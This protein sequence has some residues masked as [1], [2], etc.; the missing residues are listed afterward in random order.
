[1]QSSSIAW[2]ASKDVAVKLDVHVRTLRNW[3]D[4]F[5][6]YMV[7]Q[8][9]SQ[10]HLLLS[11]QAYQL[12]VEIK[13]RKDTGVQTLKEVEDSLR[14]DG[15]LP[16]RMETEDLNPAT[17]HQEVPS[18]AAAAIMEKLSEL[19]S[20]INQQFY[21]SLHEFTE[22]YRQTASSM[23]LVVLEASR[24]ERTS[25]APARGGA[26]STEIEQQYKNIMRKM[27]EIEDKQEN[28]R[29]EMRKMN[30]DIQMLGATDKLNKK[31]RKINL[32]GSLFRKAPQISS[33]YHS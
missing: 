17:A 26:A 5:S 20:S 1:M 8:K 27:E 10:G 4:A 18:Q 30:F 29:L 13:K 19:E 2:M 22:A 25:P 15:L 11:E 3:I 24:S 31:H 16:D 28:I 9:N 6:P 7:L 32:F 33:D 23:E 21:E 14:A 12:L